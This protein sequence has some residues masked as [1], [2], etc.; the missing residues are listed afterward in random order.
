MPEL[1]GEELRLVQTLDRQLRLNRKR[2]VHYDAYYEGEQPLKYMA[3]A[4][5]AE[6]GHIVSQVVIEWPSMVVD[7]YE[8]RSDVEGF[9]FPDR[10]GG[11]ELLWDV[12]QASNLDEQSSEGHT[13]SLIH[14]GAFIITG[15]GD[16]KG[17]MPLVTVE[18]PLQVAV[19]RDGA[20]RQVRDG[21]KRWVDDD[22]VQWVNAYM[23]DGSRVTARKKGRYWIEDSR[24][25][26]IGRPPI[27][28]LPNR[29]RMLRPL[30]KSEMARIIPLADAANKMATDMM[31]S[32][33][34]HAMPRR[35]A[36]GMTEDD[37]L[38]EDGSPL[39]VWAQIA[40]RLWAT[41]RTKDQVEVGQFPEADLSNFHN[42]IRL[43]A[44]L[45]AQVSFLPEHYVAFTTDNPPSADSFRAGE[46]RMLKLCER[47]HTVWGGRGWEESA[48]HQLR[49]LDGHWDPKAWRIETQWRNPATPTF[50][51]MADAA[52]KLAGG[53]GR[54]IIPVRQAREDIGY[55][56]EQLKRM[57]EW[58][59][60]DAD[61]TLFG[62]AAE[63]MRLPLGAG[64]GGDGGGT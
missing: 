27:A 53:G 13:E 45:V 10:K 23:P 46:T 9:R 18:H 40:G 34:F 4:L 33:E 26:G 50:A 41:E 63:Q 2:I 5:E 25:P 16:T 44:Q 51:Q 47:K 37:F 14:G 38:D 42:T 35:Y 49:Y 20:T 55:S 3:P 8:H 62:T 7:A 60:E 31:V 24:A 58:D 36:I 30:G 1:A 57:E 22:D 61:R 11:S 6:I 48:R 15:P 21:I 64:A 56:P 28:E 54:P 59:R 32:G 19:R 29:A 39:S 17:D 43:L 52:V 12:W